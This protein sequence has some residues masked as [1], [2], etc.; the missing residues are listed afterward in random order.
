M[1]LQEVLTARLNLFCFRPIGIVETIMITGHTV[2][3]VM[4]A[5]LV[6]L[7]APERSRAD[8]YRFV[9]EDGVEC[10]TDSPRNGKASLYLR[11]K[12]AARPGTRRTVP[13]H[14]RA[15]GITGTSPA[16]SQTVPPPS[17]ASAAPPVQGR[18]TSLVGF[19]HDPID[20]TMREH[21]GIDIAVPEGTPVRAI[22]PGRVAFAGNR[23]GYGTMVVLEHPDGII[24]LY[25]HNSMNAV[26]EGA[27]VSAGD[28]IALSGSTGR[29]TGPHLHFEAWRGDVNVTSSYLPGARGDRIGTAATPRAADTIRKILQA[30]GTILLTNH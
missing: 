19:R 18:I 26:V 1:L 20:G 5:A 11:E 4:L 24:T 3:I 27:S 17:D 23:P 10:F 28:T 7:T 8:I 25:A 6:G 15:T 22:A 9:D 14:L 13:H 16:I 21:R 12:K 2:R 30:D 29:S